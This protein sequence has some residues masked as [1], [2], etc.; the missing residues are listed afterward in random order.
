M[1]VIMLDSLR[2]QRHTALT[3]KVQL[4]FVVAS[5]A[6]GGTRDKPENVCVGGY[7]P[8][9]K[10]WDMKQVLPSPHFQCW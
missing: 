1:G 4:R 5:H 3:P 2:K 7:N 10:S 6:D 8:R 9:Q